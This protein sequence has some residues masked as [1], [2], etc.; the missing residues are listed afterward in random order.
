VPL[1]ERTQVQEVPRSLTGDLVRIGAACIAGVLVLGGYTSLR[2]WQQG[3]TDEAGRPADAIV[4]LGAAQYNGRPSDVFAARLDHAVDLYLRG[5][6]PRLIVTGGRADG[7]T[8]AE[9]DVAR[10]YALAR[11]VPE[12]AILDESSGRDTVESLGN[13]AG[14]MAR[15]G[16]HSALFVS[17]PTHML[18]VLRIADDLGIE[19]YGSPTRSGPLAHDPA[20]WVAAATHELGALALYLTTGR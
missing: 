20:M 18:R 14:V 12:S 6:A 3:Q 2:I 13:V 9:A 8:S 11:G 7:D 17:D 10:A 4:V 16:L 1:R 5:V 19:S 15:N